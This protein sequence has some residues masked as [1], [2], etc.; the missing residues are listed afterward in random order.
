MGKIKKNAKDLKSFLLV[1][2]LENEVSSKGEFLQSMIDKEH[3][4][5]RNL[6]YKAHAAI[7]KIVI[8][9]NNFGAITVETKPSNVVIKRRNDKE[10]QLLV[11]PFSTWSVHNIELKLTKIIDST[12]NNTWGC[13]MLPDGRFA[14]PDYYSQT[15]RVFNTDGTFSFDVKT[16][17]CVCDIAYISEDNTLA[18]S[19]GGSD[20]QGIEQWT[21][22]NESILKEPRGISVDND[23]NVYVVGVESFNVV[24]ISADGKQYKE[25]FIVSDD[26]LDPYTLD[27]NKSTNQ[28]LVA[29]NSN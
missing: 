22:Q 1:K 12:G 4:Q 28:L 9:I 26:L 27:Y 15:I 17:T 13:S 18:V 25:L 14:F 10:E 11:P 21:F 6:S 23:G 20:L 5:E 8:D 19:S 3:F 29:D 16:S 7:Q 24:V 2:Y